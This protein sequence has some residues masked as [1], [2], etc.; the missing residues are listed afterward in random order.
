MTTVAHEIVYNSGRLL[1]EAL[2]A[3]AKDSALPAMAWNCDAPN[4]DNATRA[5]F[6]TAVE[7]AVAS[8]AYIVS[9]DR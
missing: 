1:A 2:A 9:R 4:G 7:A 5:A 8:S 6:D 3:M